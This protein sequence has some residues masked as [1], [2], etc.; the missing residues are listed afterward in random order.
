MPQSRRRNSGKRSVPPRSPAVRWS[1][2]RRRWEQAVSMESVKR[3]RWPSFITSRS[4]TSSMVCFFVL[5]AGNLLVQVVKN[6]VQPDTGGSPPSGILKDLGMLA[7]LP[8]IT[9]RKHQEFR[10]RFQLLHPV[11]DLVDGLAAYLPCRT[12]GSGA[13]PLWPRGAGG[14]RKFP[15][16]CPRWSRGVLGCCF[17]VDGDGGDRPSMASTSGLSICPR[18]CRA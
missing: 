6:A 4:T 3:R 7:L 9:G 18:N 16:P 12:W 5:L 2:G 1:Q 15:S 14:S 8:R 11:H 10:P 13:R 17:L